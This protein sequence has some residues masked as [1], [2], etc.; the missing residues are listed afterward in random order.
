[1]GFRVGCYWPAV[2]QSYAPRKMKS[3]IF[4]RRSTNCAAKSKKTKAP[5][6][7]R[8]STPSLKAPKALSIRK[9]GNQAWQ[10]RNRRPSANLGHD[11]L[12]QRRNPRRLRRFWQR[13]AGQQR[14]AHPPR[15]V[16]VHHELNENVT[17]V[18]MFDA[19][20]SHQLPRHDQQFP[21]LFK[22]MPSSTQIIN[23]VPNPDTVVNSVRNGTASSNRILQDAYINI[24]DL[25]PHR[26]SSPSA[27]SA[28]RRVKK[29]R[30]ATPI[31]TSSNAPWSI[32]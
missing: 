18:T 5:R 30:A 19:A 24:H 31:W 21:G 9:S 32:N 29:A 3:K 8:A 28:R 6:K 7:S 25:I 20:R 2:C 22:S 16:E 4:A 15:R 13:R 26:R 17:A 23:G 27:S 11:F 12:A 10:T 1:M 14:H